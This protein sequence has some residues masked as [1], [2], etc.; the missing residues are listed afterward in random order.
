MAF[1]NSQKEV[2]MKTIYKMFAIVCFLTLKIS[3]SPL[4]ELLKQMEATEELMTTPVSVEVIEDAY[5]KFNTCII[6]DLKNELK[7]NTVEEKLE[8]L[9][10]YFKNTKNGLYFIWALGNGVFQELQK[11][12][13]NDKMVLVNIQ[14]VLDE[15]GLFIRYL[16]GLG[17]QNEDN[18]EI[19]AVIDGCLRSPT[20][21]CPEVNPTM[22][23]NEHLRKWSNLTSFESLFNNYLKKYS[24]VHILDK[25]AYPI[26]DTKLIGAISFPFIHYASSY[27]KNQLYVCLYSLAN[28]IKDKNTI[29]ALVELEKK[30]T[31][32]DS[33]FPFGMSRIEWNLITANPQKLYY[34]EREVKKQESSL[35]KENGFM[36]KF[37]T[38]KTKKIPLN[39]EIFSYEYE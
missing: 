24:D 39:I 30:M 2:T 27:F 16:E 32:S 33:N 26:Q 35:I 14:S 7:A 18:I 17:K 5:K 21:T 37:S 13:N 11:K 31:L 36:I 9:D 38:G 4:N 3:A 20:V 25:T 6:N 8:V 23:N 34:Y 1:N 15:E 22:E 19:I 10:C 12:Y 28:E 29:N